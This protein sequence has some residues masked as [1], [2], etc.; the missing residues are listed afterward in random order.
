MSVQDGLKMQEIKWFGDT[1]MFQKLAVQQVNYT[2]SHHQMQ[3]TGQS[4]ALHVY[5]QTQ[6]EI[7]P[8]IHH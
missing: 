7:I 8:F 4:F 3:G 1:C 5:Y 2:K 6:G